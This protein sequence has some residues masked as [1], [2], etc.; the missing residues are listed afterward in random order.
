MFNSPLPAQLNHRTQWG[1][2]THALPTKMPLLEEDL[3]IDELDPALEAMMAVA[4]AS[5]SQL[6]SELVDDGEMDALAAL[7]AAALSR[8]R[9][10]S[11]SRSRSHSH[12]H[13]PRPSPKP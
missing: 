3:E 12:G 10:S 11:R 1:R 5:S 4:D 8:S 13:R 9:S 7:E 2:L 6:Q